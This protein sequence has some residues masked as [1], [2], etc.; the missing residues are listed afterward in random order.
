[1]LGVSVK[2]NMPLENWLSDMTAEPLISIEQAFEAV[3]LPYS[4]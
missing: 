1:M 4:K 2:L 3:E